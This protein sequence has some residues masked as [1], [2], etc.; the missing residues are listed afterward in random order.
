MGL[1][2]GVGADVAGLV[3][4][5]VEGLVTEG[6]L[7]GAVL[8]RRHR[9]VGGTGRGQLGQGERNHFGQWCLRRVWGGVVG[10][11]KMRD[12]RGAGDVLFILAPPAPL[13]Q[14]PTRRMH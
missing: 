1:L 3:L 6:A 2:A 7:V 8:L 5:A 9:G 13:L 12:E 14:N 4:Q 11:G 10:E